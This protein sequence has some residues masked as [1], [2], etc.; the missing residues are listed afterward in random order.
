VRWVRHF[1]DSAGFRQAAGEDTD[2][3]QWLAGLRAWF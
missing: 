3:W 1:G 2:E